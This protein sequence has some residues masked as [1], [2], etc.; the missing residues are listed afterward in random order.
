MK[1][2]TAQFKVGSDKIQYET[3]SKNVFTNKDLSEA[4]ASKNERLRNGQE[5][6][7]ANFS[8]GND[9]NLENKRSI[10]ATI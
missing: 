6:K 9:T 5:V 2:R 8:L 1:A 10:N 4:I 7:S 3:L